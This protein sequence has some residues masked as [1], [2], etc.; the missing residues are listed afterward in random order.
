MNTLQIGFVAAALA[1][2]CGHASAQSA[3]QTIDVG[4]WKVTDSHDGEEFRGCTAIKKFDDGSAIGLAATKDVTLLIVSEPKS[5][6]TA[7]QQ[8]QVTYRFDGGKPTAAQGQ[9]KAADSLFVQIPDADVE[10]FMTS[11][12]ITIS[13]GGID[14]EEPLEGSKDAVTAMA[15]CMNNGAAAK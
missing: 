13:Y 15:T 12:K 6:L 3:N 8:Y 9:A 14:F 1:L 5:G 2:V 4:A 10:P 11:T 7:D